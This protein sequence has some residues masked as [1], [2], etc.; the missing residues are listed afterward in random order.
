MPAT[1]QR[2]VVCRRACVA[3]DV[4]VEERVYPVVELLMFGGGARLVECLFGDVE[5]ADR[6]GVDV[7]GGGGAAA[8]RDR[9]GPSHADVRAGA[10]GTGEANLGFEG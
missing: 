2:V 3:F 10:H 7:A 8:L 9:R 4:A 1:G 6:L 5:A